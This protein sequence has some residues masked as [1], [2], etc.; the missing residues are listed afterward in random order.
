MVVM[1]LVVGARDATCLE[2]LLILPP[3]VTVTLTATVMA[4]TATGAQDATRLEP[5][6]CFIYFI[7]LLH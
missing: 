6:V 4:A 1:V 3:L 5:L 2:P 7:L